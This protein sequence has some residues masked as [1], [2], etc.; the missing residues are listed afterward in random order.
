MRALGLAVGDQVQVSMNLIDPATVGPAQVYDEVAAEA[1]VARA[2]LVG[3]VPRAI[4][5][6]VEPTRWALLDLSEEQTIE[7]RLEARGLSLP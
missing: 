5:H 1:P 2:E 7:A 6:E 3:L 4:L